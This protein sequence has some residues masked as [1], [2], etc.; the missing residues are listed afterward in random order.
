M[1][2][3]QNQNAS[4]RKRSKTITK[5]MI[6]HPEFGIFGEKL[7]ITGYRPFDPFPVEVD[8]DEMRWVIK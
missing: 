8:V 5:M 4:K 2:G 3:K 7:F 6:H 1:S